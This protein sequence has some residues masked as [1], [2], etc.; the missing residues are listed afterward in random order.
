MAAGYP[1]FYA[2]Q[3]IQ[4]YERIVSGKGPVP[5]S[6][7]PELKDFAQELTASGPDKALRQPQERVADIKN[8]KWFTTTDW[9]AT[10]QR[11]M[12]VPFVPPNKGPGDA[13]NFDQYDEPPLVIADTD[14]FEK[15]LEE[16]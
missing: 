14:R 16:F 4:I 12:E 10:F 13:S 6:L 5:V 3:P 2:D 15:E 7:L 8:H 9:I 11:K 1:P